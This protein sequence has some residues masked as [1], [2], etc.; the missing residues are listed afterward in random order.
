VLL[1]GVRIGQKTLNNPVDTGKI[2]VIVGGTYVR[3]GPVR[4]IW[5]DDVAVFDVK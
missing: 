5:F 4:T 1:D 2:G 3:D